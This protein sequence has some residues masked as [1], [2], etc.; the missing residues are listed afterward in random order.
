MTKELG[1]RLRALRKRAG[2]T[3]TELAR[4]VSS[5]WAHSL[6]AKLETGRYE[7]PGFGLVADYLRACRASFADLADL[8][9]A[10]TSS[11]RPVEKQGKEK[12][13][14]A[15][16]VLPARISCEVQK[17]DI[18]TTIARRV[19]GKLPLSPDER[20][21]RV[22][23]LAAAANRRKR[24][25]ILVAYLEGEVGPGLDAGARRFVDQFSR[26]VWGALSATRG[27]APGKRVRR[28][29]L[30]YADGVVAHVLSEDKLRLLRD[31]VAELFGAMEM[32]GALGPMPQPGKTWHRK[33]AFERELKAMT[34][35]QLAREAYIGTSL[36][37]AMK[38]IQGGGAP[39]DRHRSWY[40][41]L[42]LLL[43]NA[44]DTSPGSPERGKVLTEALKDRP[45]K[46]QAR[47]FAA[48]ALDG[49]DRQLRRK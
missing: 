23:N 18:K 21:K 7:N 17:Y 22:L 44:Y 8:L 16:A 36:S 25:D 6:V 10:Y 48:L 4:L 46:E 28:M 9:D 43:S 47:K 26:K 27:K 45:D 13:A 42:T 20:V 19:E 32:T 3:Q 15:I 12:V 39:R 33:S 40:I 31:R 11:P 38:L 49:L 30:V 34:P 1:Q 5:D 2:L 35:A 14:E 41:W 24:L 37:D 29:A